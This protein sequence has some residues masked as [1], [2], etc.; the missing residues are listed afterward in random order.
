MS[1]RKMWK[2]YLE[3]VTEIITVALGMATVTIVLATAAAI[4][5]AIVRW[6]W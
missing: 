3:F 6:C 5:G 4:A 1:W 2:D